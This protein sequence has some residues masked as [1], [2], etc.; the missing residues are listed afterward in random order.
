MKGRHTLATKKLVLQSLNYFYQ[1]HM[2]A[3]E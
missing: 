3:F 2:T 1:G